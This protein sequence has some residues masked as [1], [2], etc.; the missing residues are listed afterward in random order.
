MAPATPHPRLARAG[1]ASLGAMLLATLLAPAAA[2]WQNENLFAITDSDWPQACANAGSVYACVGL[3]TPYWESGNVFPSY[4]LDDGV[5]VYVS[6][7]G[8]DNSQIGYGVGTYG[9]GYKRGNCPGSVETSSEPD[10]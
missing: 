7:V 4:N 3:C 8:P 9:A 2:A 5:Y 6:G 10:P 1:L